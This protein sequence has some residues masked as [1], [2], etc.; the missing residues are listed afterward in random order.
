MCCVI[1]A[2]G[3]VGSE[4]HPSDKACKSQLGSIS[5]GPVSEG[6][7]CWAGE[8]QETGTGQHILPSRLYREPFAAPQKG[9]TTTHTL[10]GQVTKAEG[11]LCLE[12]PHLSSHLSGPPEG[13]GE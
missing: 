8:G 2:V 9:P 10:G 12:G 13:K 1:H 5:S 7:N 11:Y 3:L 6:V 4:K